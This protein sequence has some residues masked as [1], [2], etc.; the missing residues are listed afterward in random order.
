MSLFRLLSTSL[1]C[2]CLIMTT[3]CSNN[4]NPIASTSPINITAGTSAANNLVIEPNSSSVEMGKSTKL[5][6]I[7]NQNGQL[8]KDLP[9]VW[10]S[11]T[12]DFLTV[13]A[14]GTVTGLKPGSSR[15][16]VSIL[17]QEAF[18]LINVTVPTATTGSPPATTP[19]ASASPAAGVSTA[20]DS[21]A[22]SPELAKLRTII[23]KPIDQTTQPTV[24]TMSTLGEQKQFE[25]IGKDAEGQTIP[26]LTFK[27]TSSAETIATVNSTGMVAAVKTGVTNLI[28]TAGNVTS[29]TVVVQV[30]HGI[31]NANIKF[32]E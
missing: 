2:L 22:A 32:T 1:A 20:S 8:K 28:A 4:D 5:S 23:I 13:D 29:N 26:N 24:F 12:P 30:Q 21:T 10:T 31:V 16:K 17:G 15:V 25:A 18:A 27:W 7:F 14:S 9:A 11:L 19:T 6:A 3:S